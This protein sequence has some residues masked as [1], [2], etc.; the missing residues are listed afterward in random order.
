MINTNALKGIIVSRGESQRSIARVLG[1]SE[2]A[3]YNKMKRGKFNSDE[4]Y[5]MI[6]YLNI[7]QPME[8]F[9]TDEVS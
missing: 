8:I 2:P 3:F 7:Q 4:I 1:L 9:F 5:E 6:K